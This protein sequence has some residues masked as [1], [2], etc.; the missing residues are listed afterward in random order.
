VDPFVIDVEG[1]HYIFVE[2]FDYALGRGMISTTSIGPNGQI[3]TPRVV[4]E[5]P[6]HLSYPFV[7]KHDGHIWMIP[8]S[9]A[10]S[11]VELYR[12]DPF[13]DHWVLEA[14]LLS[15]I[16]VADATLS[17][18]EGRWW[19]FA[20][21]VKHKSSS[22]DAL[23]IFHASNLAGPWRPHFQNPVLI[24][25]RAAR[26]GGKMFY[27]DNILWRPAQDCSDG[28]GSAITICS[29]DVLDTENYAQT[30]RAL[31]GSGNFARRIHTLNWSS[32]VEVIDGWGKAL[33]A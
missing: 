30:T 12:A 18:H 27:R 20:S 10:A 28:Y 31:I 24:D 3:G 6:W 32:G 2:E 19:M 22:W 11:T 25:S 16:C 33:P 4:L 1:C 5:K 13:P 23:S 14:T 8:E 7:F 9:S 26:P 15:D 21:T 29:V 17:F